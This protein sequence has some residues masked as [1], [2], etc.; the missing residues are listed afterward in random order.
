MA[1]LCYVSK[2]APEGI[3]NYIRTGVCKKLPIEH[4]D[5]E[6][7]SYCVLHQPSKMK[8]SD[9]DFI[10]VVKDRVA[11]G[12][13][14]FRYIYVPESAA[15]FDLSFNA[16]A[17]FNFALFDCPA[18]FRNRIFEHKISFANAVF[19]KDAV[20]NNTVFKKETDF[21]RAKFDE[22]VKFDDAVFKEAVDF[23]SASFIYKGDFKRTTFLD[24]T[25]FTKAIFA[26]EAD[27]YKAEFK[28]KADFYKTTFT[29]KADF[30]EA[31]F[32]G[33]AYFKTTNFEKTSRTYFHRV[34]FGGIANFSYSSLEGYLSFEGT[35][36][37]R[38]LISK[39]SWLDLQKTRI[40]DG[41]KISFH[42]V[43]LEPSWFV[44]CDA[45][46]FIFTDCKWRYALPK[47]GKSNVSNSTK[48]IQFIKYF[49]NRKLRYATLKFIKN[50][51]PSRWKQIIDRKRLSVDVELEN[52]SKRVSKNP[53]P[54]LT[55]TCWQL[56]DNHEESK[57]FPKASVFRLMANESMRLEKYKGWKIWSWNWWYWLSS[58]Y[59]ESPLRAL[60]V[61][62][63]ILLLF[64]VA[65]M[66]TDF[67]ICP[68]IKTIPEI[69]CQARTLSVWESALQSLATATFQNIEYIKP[70]SKITTFLI[71]LE[72]IL[73]PLQAA[74]LA[75]A[76]RRKFMR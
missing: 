69:A 65:F 62:V 39:K 45:S 63:G 64:V 51:N 11:S 1:K 30:T 37:D 21:S 59:G 4:L 42:T 67:Q 26:G 49:S 41:K 18:D 17:N 3:K 44:N 12:Q 35:P 28:A 73:A 6:S 60:L 24:K 25:D 7:H 76:I 54:I 61:L 29:V 38:M 52:L 50:T 53:H 70:N 15:F 58:F 14:D 2:D 55:K 36:E 56:A 5:T 74:L 16:D 66:L 34:K 75:L 72:K 27:F 46:E 13:N 68:I 10:S 31:V 48:S 33:E 22:K 57:S 9:T 20:F 19:S 23:R 8:L 43:R 32:I 40:A 71:I 47:T